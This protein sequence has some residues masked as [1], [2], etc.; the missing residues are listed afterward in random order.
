[1]NHRFYRLLE[2]AKIPA[3]DMEDVLSERMQDA[4]KAIK[5]QF[6]PEFT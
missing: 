4:T 5:R 6:A 3:V 1:M 2:D